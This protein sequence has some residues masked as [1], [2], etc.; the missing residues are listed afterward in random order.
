MRQYNYVTMAESSFSKLEREANL[1]QR[2]GSEI[3]ALI[4]S[5]KLQPDQRLPAERDLAEQF[6][7]SRTVIREAVKGLAAR[8]MVQVSHGRAGTVVR[9]PTHNHLTDMM[10]LYLRGG[11]LTGEYGDLI[12]VRRIIEVSI[13]GFAAERRAETDISAMADNLAHMEAVVGNRDQYVDLDLAFHMLVAQATRNRLF[14][15]LI[16]SV[17]DLMVGVRREAYRVHGEP[18]NTLAQHRAIFNAIEKANPTAAREA[19]LQHIEWGQR[20]LHRALEMRSR[21]AKDVPENS[22]SGDSRISEENQWLI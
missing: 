22:I 12:E 11:D 3:E 21:A 4:M 1:S 16:D 10:T 17:N 8:G 2:V 15:L 19:M 20:V 14:P 18:S 6:G 9:L 5:G 7:V 13:A